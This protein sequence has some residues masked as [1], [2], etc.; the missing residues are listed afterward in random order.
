MDIQLQVI[1][2]FREH[3]NFLFF[4]GVQAADGCGIKLLRPLETQEVTNVGTTCTNL[5]IGSEPGL[6]WL[7]KRMDRRSNWFRLYFIQLIFTPYI[8]IQFQRSL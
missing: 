1:S 7:T 4:S 2:S 8:W 6:D 3:F 5:Y